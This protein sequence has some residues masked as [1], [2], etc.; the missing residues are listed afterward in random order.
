MTVAIARSQKDDL[1]SVLALLP[2]GNFQLRVDDSDPYKAEQSAKLIAE[3]RDGLASFRAGG[4]PRPVLFIP[5]LYEEDRRAWRRLEPSLRACGRP[6]FPPGSQDPAYLVTPAQ[7]RAI[8]PWLA[9]RDARR[10]F[11]SPR[12][13]R[14][15][16]LVMIL[17]DGF[18]P[19]EVRPAA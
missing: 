2:D 5:G 17:G 6:I 10:R 16:W 9:R 14:S 19:A 8:Y 11:R 7:A 1:M 12:W 15:F 3:L 4:V 13:P 18:F